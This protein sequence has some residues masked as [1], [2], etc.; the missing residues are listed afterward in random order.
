MDRALANTVTSSAK[1]VRGKG[2]GR[3]GPVFLSSVPGF[4]ARM[5]RSAIRER[6]CRLHR[7]PGLRFAPSGLRRKLK[8]AER[9]QTLGNNRRILRCG[10]R[11]FGARTLDGV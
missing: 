6:H 9:R 8:E 7:R 3:G 10:A 2:K 11:P 4:V 1:P 5:E